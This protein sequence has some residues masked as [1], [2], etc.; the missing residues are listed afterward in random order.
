MVRPSSEAIFT[1][2]A[3][4]ITAT[5]RLVFVFMF[6]LA[7]LQTVFYPTHGLVSNSGES[8]RTHEFTAKT[9]LPSTRKRICLR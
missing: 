3:R 8:W 6:V 2:A 1:E 7:F 5:K 9:R 4:N